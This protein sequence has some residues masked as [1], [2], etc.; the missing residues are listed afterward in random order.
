MTI[1]LCSVNST[2]QS[3][4]L[5]CSL[6]SLV[7][8]LQLLQIINNM[9]KMAPFYVCIKKLSIKRSYNGEAEATNWNP[10]G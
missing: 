6:V 8:L 2:L 1:Q 7:F 4:M 3:V 9:G 5:S 10:I